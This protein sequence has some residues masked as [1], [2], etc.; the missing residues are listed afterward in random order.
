MNKTLLAT[1]LALA[2]ITAN[3]TTIAVVDLEVIKNEYAKAKAMDAQLKQAL[4]NTRAEMQ[5]REEKL[6][7][8]QSEAEYADKAARDPMIKEEARPAKQAEAKAKIEEFL[9]EQ[10]TA[11]QFGQQAGQ[12]FQTRAQ[13]V[14]R[15]IMTEV[16]AK[17]EVIAKER[18]IDIVLPKNIVLAADATLDISAEV[19]KRLNESYA[20]NPVNPAAPAAPAPGAVTATP[21][22]ASAATTPAAK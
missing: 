4:D 7:K 22:A 11:R 10:N 8:L 15:D 17:S 16:K 2:A 18:K 14:D 5:G 13:Q 20:A 6:K 1:T 3:A 21:A 19:V 12:Y 9:K